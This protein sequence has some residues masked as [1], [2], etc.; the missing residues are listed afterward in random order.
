VLA[1]VWISLLTTVT[2]TK[3]KKKK[4]GVVESLGTYYWSIAWVDLVGE[5]KIQQL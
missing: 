3:K 1:C 2:V 5:G 4:K